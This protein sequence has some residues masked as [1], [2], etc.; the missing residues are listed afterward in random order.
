MTIEK[1]IRITYLEET[2]Q[3]CNRI[4]LFLVKLLLEELKFPLDLQGKLISCIDKN[5]RNEK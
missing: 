5:R 3:S 2:E 4:H 1:K